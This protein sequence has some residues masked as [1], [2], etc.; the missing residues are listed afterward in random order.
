[1]ATL[2]GNRKVANNRGTAWRSKLVGGR[3]DSEMR[4]TVLKI[5]R[6]QKL[7]SQDQLA[8]DLGV[9]LSTYGA[10][11]RGRRSVTK[12]TAAKLSSLLGASVS[13]LFTSALR[14][15]Y[16]AMKAK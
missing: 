3:L 6:A 2:E 11:E 14:G 4:P 8:D 1:M 13:T 16:V 10:I 5:R 7:V 12:E 15:K 9:S